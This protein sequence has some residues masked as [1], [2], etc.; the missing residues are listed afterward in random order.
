MPELPEVETICRGLKPLV[1]GRRITGVEILER[2]LRR[3]VAP[4]LGSRLVGRTIVDVGRRAKYLLILL[5]AELVWLFH[6]G[7]S[8]KLVYAAAEKAREKHDHIIARLDNGHELRYHDPRRFGLSM[9]VTRSKLENLPQMRNLG[10]DPFERRF[11]GT[12]LY[13]TARSSR[14]RI[15]DLLI[16]Q[17]VAAGLGNIYANEILFRAGVRPT[18]RA[19]KLGRGKVE[20]IARATPALLREAIRWCGTSFSD[21]RD[22]EDRFGKF[23][24]HLKVYDRE[25]KGCKACG[26]AIKRVLIGNRSAFYCPRCQK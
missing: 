25:G 14:R 15:R 21:Y 6:L 9:V 2:R 20:R 12:Y 22:A 8:G 7:M 1:S 23:Q 13:A 24:N 26:S 5:D 16:D 3:R 10:L 11:S 18:A 19:W 17:R 4:R